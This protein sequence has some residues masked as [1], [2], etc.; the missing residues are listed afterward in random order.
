MSCFCV[1]MLLLEVLTFKYLI[2]W[3]LYMIIIIIRS[4]FVK[5]HFITAAEMVHR[6]LR[7]GGAHHSQFPCS[8]KFRSM[9][10]LKWR[11]SDNLSHDWVMRWTDGRRPLDDSNVSVQSSIS[12]SHRSKTGLFS[13]NG[14][15]GFFKGLVRASLYKITIAPLA[16]AFL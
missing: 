8:R 13:H 16:Y 9:I 15:V 7:H 4:L 1:L 2:K 5:S 6:V 11:M 10:H 3:L 14:L 12:C